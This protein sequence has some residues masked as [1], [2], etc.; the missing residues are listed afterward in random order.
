M[1]FGIGTDIVELNR[2]KNLSNLDKFSKKIL[3]TN[4][5]KYYMT[6]N[7]KERIR[8]L[9]KQFAGKE[10]IVKALGEGFNK[11]IKISS[12]EILRDDKGRPICNIQDGI[13][14]IEIKNIHI[15]L[16]DEDKYA[17]GFAILEI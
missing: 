9:A 13:Y 7:P 2:F 4:E 3:S 5:I 1:I 8:Y 11:K 6:I 14:D 12:I 15:S 17:I 10:S 16:S